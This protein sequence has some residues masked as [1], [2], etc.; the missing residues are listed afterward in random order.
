MKEKIQRELSLV[1]F[2][3]TRAEK[4]ILDYTSRIE[5]LMGD[6]RVREVGHVKTY[7]EHLERVDNEKRQLEET[8]RMLE[9]FLAD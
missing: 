2:R 7:A 1:E 8:K 6:F 9:Y 3:I 4:E 5:R